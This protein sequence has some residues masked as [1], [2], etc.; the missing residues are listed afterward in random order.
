MCSSPVPDPTVLLGEKV[1]DEIHIF[2]ISFLSKSLLSEK[3]TCPLTKLSISVTS[4]KRKTMNELGQGAR[5]K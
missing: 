1:A 4:H 5:S 2:P 3:G